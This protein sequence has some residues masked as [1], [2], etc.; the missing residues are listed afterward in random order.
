MDKPSIDK[1]YIEEHSSFR[2]DRDNLINNDK[3]CFICDVCSKEAFGAH[4]WVKEEKHVPDDGRLPGYDWL[5][6]PENWLC[7]WTQNGPLHVC[8]K[9]CAIRL[10]TDLFYDDDEEV[11]EE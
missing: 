6:C 2:R 11:I 7:M 10:N 4:L 8:S 1:D 9:M 3:V 5:S